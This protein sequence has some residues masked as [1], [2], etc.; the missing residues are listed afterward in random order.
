MGAA[1]YPCCVSLL[2][3]RASFLGWCFDDTA[4]RRFDDQPAAYDIDN[5]RLQLYDVQQSALFVSE[6]IA[7]Q[8]LTNAAG[9]AGAAALPLLKQQ[10]ATMAALVNGSLW[11]D[12]TGEKKVPPIKLSSGATLPD[13]AIS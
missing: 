1:C 3:L 12:A 6:S 5:G 13:K 8:Q 2:T 9:A 7:L 4:P 10:A 11:D